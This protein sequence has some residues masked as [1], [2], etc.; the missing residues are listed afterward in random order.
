VLPNGLAKLYYGGA[1]G[2]YYGSTTYPSKCGI[3]EE[4][5]SKQKLSLIISSINEE[6]LGQ[7]QQL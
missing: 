6:T 4:E 7:R 3:K 2:V 5:K 1:I